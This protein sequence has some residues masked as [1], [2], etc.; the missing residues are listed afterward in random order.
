MRSIAF[1]SQKGG[2]GKTTLAVHLAVASEAAGER[3]ML[4]DTDPQGSA[5][6]WAQARTQECPI[7]EKATAASLHRVL[8]Q[9]QQ[10]RITL[11]VIDTAPHTAPGVDTVAASADFLLIPCRPSAF[12]LAAIAASVQIAKAVGKP[13]AFILNACPAR[14]PEIEETREVLTA[15]ALPIAPV[16]IGDRRAFA[17]VV[18]SG[19]AVTEFDAEG[20]AAGEIITLCRWVRKHIGGKNA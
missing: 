4:I 10:R 7:V 1:L 9:A 14:A 17:R 3:V 6:A 5:N 15:Y 8:D 16:R 11:A 19:R 20:K 12:D 2:S 13:A 18:A